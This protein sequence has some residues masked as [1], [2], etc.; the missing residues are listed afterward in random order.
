LREKEKDSCLEAA[1]K[2]LGKEQARGELRDRQLEEREREARALEREVSRVGGECMTLTLNLNLA[3]KQL[4]EAKIGT[5]RAQ[6]AL[7]KEI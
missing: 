2:E 7:A 3:Q 1:R 5:S 6:A 4:G